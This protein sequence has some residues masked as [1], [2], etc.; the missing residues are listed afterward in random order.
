MIRRHL[1]RTSIGIS[2]SLFA[3]LLALPSPLARADQG[4]KKG[5]WETVSDDDGIHV[6]RRT[7]EGTNLKEFQ[8][9]GVVDAPLTRVLAVIRDAPHRVEWMAECR[10]SYTVEVP[11]DHEQTDYH[12]T[13]APWPVSD[14]DSV[15][16]ATMHIDAEKHRMVLEF[17]AVENA[18]V[19]PVKG[20]VRMPF[21]R[22]H[23]ILAPTEKGLKTEVEYQV[24]ANPGGLLPEWLANLASKRLPHDTIAGLRKQVKKRQYPEFEAEMMKR[25][26]AAVLLAGD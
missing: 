6:A 3:L 8:G 24:H 25:P 13:R 20:V 15:N 10:E 17:E 18:K 9:R 16:H 5:P 14:R 26:E 12:R 19:P 4:G 22:G 23:W 7:V 21:L 11:S 2:G 1:V